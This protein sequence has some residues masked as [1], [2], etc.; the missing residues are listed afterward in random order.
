MFSSLFVFSLRS[1]VSTAMPCHLMP[2]GMAW[3]GIGMG[4]AM[5][6]DGLAWHGIGWEGMGHG[7]GHG[8]G[9]G[10]AVKIMDPRL[11]IKNKD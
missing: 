5:G 11:R 2:M 10:I 7:H 4:L 6:W 3:H 1:L 8:H 9:H